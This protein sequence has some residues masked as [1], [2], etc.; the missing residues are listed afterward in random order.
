MT[1]RWSMA[2][3]G[4]ASHEG[5]I[6]RTSTRRLTGGIAALAA[7]A[8]LLLGVGLSWEMS[9][10]A[11]PALQVNGVSA[12]A[13]RG[14]PRRIVKTVVVKRV[15]DSPTSSSGASKTTATF[16]P[17]TAAPAPATSSTS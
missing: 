10:G 16:T 6:K 13:L 12:S 1:G 11:D 7:V 15:V 5:R 8:S 9:R 14:S 4:I 3:S 17:V 2:T